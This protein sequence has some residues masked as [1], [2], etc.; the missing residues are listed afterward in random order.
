[1]KIKVM[2]FLRKKGNR[3]AQ[4]AIEFSD[5]TDGIMR[6]SQLVGFTICDDAEKGLF[7]LFPSSITR[8]KE[9]GEFKTYFFLKP[10]DAEFLTKLENAIL[11]VYETMIGFNQP[12][13]TGTPMLESA[14]VVFDNLKKR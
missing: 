8:F 6:G 1:M 11:D 10:L 13:M 4:A 7:I 12:R 3:V 5:D 2:P 14:K 9:A